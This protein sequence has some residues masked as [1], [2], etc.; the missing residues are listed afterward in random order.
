MKQE[1]PII[2]AEWEEVLIGPSSASGA[3]AKPNRVPKA[4]KTSLRASK[5]EEKAI[6]PRQ[7][8]AKRVNPEGRLDFLVAGLATQQLATMTG[9]TVAPETERAIKQASKMIFGSQKLKGSE[10][11]F[12]KSLFGG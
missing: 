12:L 8:Q 11:D 1:L 3:T 10:W 5:R 9:A 6:Q 2:D 7:R 4:K